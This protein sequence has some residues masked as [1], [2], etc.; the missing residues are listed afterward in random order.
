MFLKKTGQISIFLANF[1]NVWGFWLAAQLIQPIRSPPN[2]KKKFTKKAKI[3]VDEFVWKYLIFI[4]H[5]LVSPVKVLRSEKHV[6]FWFPQNKTSL[7]K[8][9]F[10]NY[11]KWS[12]LCLVLFLEACLWHHW[13]ST[14]FIFK[15]L[16][17]IFLLML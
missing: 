11:F 6:K 14:S 1:L 2:F 15:T 4:R 17:E 7:L 5:S 9:C 3:W 13:P 8:G 12:S 10:Y 16:I